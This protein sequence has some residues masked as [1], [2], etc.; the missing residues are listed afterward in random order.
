MLSRI[1][2]NAAAHVKAILGSGD[3]EAA[4]PLIADFAARMQMRFK[5]ALSAAER[6]AVLTETL[7][8]FKDWLHLSRVL[9]SHISSRLHAAIGESRY[10]APLCDRPRIE[11]EA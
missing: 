9:R 7:E 5:G 11:L 10:Q 3:F 6:E 8:T 2:E 4:E 1:S